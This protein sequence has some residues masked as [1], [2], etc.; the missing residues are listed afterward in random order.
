MKKLLLLL[1]LILTLTG[2]TYESPLKE[3]PAMSVFVGDQ[4]IKVYSGSYDWEYK[5]P[6]GSSTYTIADG[7]HPLE[8]NAETYTTAETVATLRFGAEPQ[9]VSVECWHEDLRGNTMAKSGYCNLEGNKLSLRSGPYIYA[10]HASWEGKRYRG[11][12]TSV[13]C[14]NSTAKEPI[15]TEPPQ[16]RILCGGKSTIAKLGNYSWRIGDRTD[17][18]TDS[19][20]PLRLLTAEDQFEME[21]PY[22]KLHFDVIPDRIESVAW[23]DSNLG[24]EVGGNPINE[25]WNGN[26]LA[27]YP[28]GMIIEVHA[29]WEN[30]KE[31]QGD[32]SYCFYI[33]KE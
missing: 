26:R 28:G 2:C 18:K 5:K 13:V 12:C 11:S 3:P 14:I 30:R 27:P 21:E 20:H 6:L 15:L 24:K 29:F 19:L 1:T 16:L 25:Y 9:S 8:S 4:Q 10:I 7:V 32:A 22:L 33:H 31:Y 23:Y 17:A